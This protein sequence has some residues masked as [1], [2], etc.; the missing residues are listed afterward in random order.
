MRT[1][2]ANIHLT[3]KRTGACPSSWKDEAFEA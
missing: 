1:F 2:D 3:S